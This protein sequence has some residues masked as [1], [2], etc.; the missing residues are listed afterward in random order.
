MGGLSERD[1]VGIAFAV[2]V[3]LGA[4][5][6]SCWIYSK[7]DQRKLVVAREATAGPE[8]SAEMEGMETVNLNDDVDVE[9]ADG[10]IE[11]VEKGMGENEEVGVG[12]KK[13]VGKFYGR[14][15]V[16]GV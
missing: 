1:I 5:M 7:K 8:Q 14:G 15:A 13:W 6:F 10:A 2:I 3:C 12:I 16:R 9:K 11:K 4:G